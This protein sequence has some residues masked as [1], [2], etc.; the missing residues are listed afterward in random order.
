MEQQFRLAE[1]EVNQST[2][3]EK[4]VGVFRYDA[5][6]RGKRKSTLVILVEIHSTLYVYE[7]LLDVLNSAAEHAR[8]LTSGFDTDPMARFEKLV[9]CLNDAVAQFLQQEPSPIAW[10]RI[11]MFLIDLSDGHLCLAGLGRLANIFLQKQED[12]T[13]KKFDLFSSLEQPVEIDVMKPF[14]ALL[15]GDMRPGDILFAGTLNFERLRAEL[16]LVER[17]T[18]TPPV[19]AALEIRQE[20]EQRNI[21]DDFAGVVIT[22]TFNPPKETVADTTKEEGNK[23]T[24]SI[25]KM[26][27]EEEETQTML[28]PALTPLGTPSR[29]S[30]KVLWTEKLKPF[31]GRLKDRAQDLTKRAP[32]SPQDPLAMASLRGLNA[33]HGDFMTQ[34]RKFILATCAVL[35]VVTVGGTIWYRYAKR[36]A[37]EQ[38]LWNLS[39]DQA[40]DKKNRADA[41]LVYGNEAQARSLL[42]EARVIAESLDGEKPARQKAKD[43]LNAAL[44]EVATKLR[45]EVLVDHPTE[46]LAAETTTQQAFKAIQIVKGTLYIVDPSQSDLIR[47]NPST[48]EVKRITLPVTSTVIGLASSPDSVIALTNDQAI[49]VDGLSGKAVTAPFALGKATSVQSPMIYNRRLYTLDASGNMIWKYAAV[50][51]G[52]GSPTAYLKQNTTQLGDA[53]AL[54]IDSNVYIA[55]KDG[56]L[57]RYLSGAEEVWAAQPIDPPLTSAAGLWTSLDTDRLVVTDPV[58]KRVLV[59]R[60]DGQLIAQIVSPEFQGPTFVTADLTAKKIFVVDGAR[61]LSL[62]LP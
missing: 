38:T 18:T 6:L 42:N 17:L 52:F 41:D 50:E 43:E 39:Y 31:L 19:T 3:D 36:A 59:F 44:N 34:K 7:Q 48:K 54:T 55:F 60:K 56:R 5:D 40:M 9:Q 61:V 51:N 27:S 25:E 16:E 22:S 20:L 4:I 21:P 53:V 37:A 57:M 47:V 13:Y 11:N 15:C 30:M 12:G 29:K 2:L 46:V 24:A 1:I 28:S 14:A 23:S 35:L 33:G 26:Y 32:R 62:D 45:H 49:I 10:N 58:G 8:R